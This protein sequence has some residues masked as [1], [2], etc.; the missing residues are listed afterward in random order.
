MERLSEDEIQ[1]LFKEHDYQKTW[2]GKLSK[3]RK[4]F[5]Q[6]L[7]PKYIKKQRAKRRAEREQY[8]ADIEEG[9]GMSDAEAQAA[10]KEFEYLN[11]WRG[12]LEEK[13][14]DF[15][16]RIKLRYFPKKPQGRLTNDEIET[17]LAGVSVKEEDDINPQPERER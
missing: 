7:N 1:K 16:Q 3:M 6:S 4:D 5:V 17:L 9:Y 11:S 8:L 13:L 2:R 12:R 15:G 14:W 10:V